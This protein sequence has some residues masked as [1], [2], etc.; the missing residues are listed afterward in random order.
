V[1]AQLNRGRQHLGMPSP[2]PVLGDSLPLPVCNGT[3]RGQTLRRTL[4]A[5]L[6]MIQQMKVDA[7]GPLTAQQASQLQEIEMDA[8][9]LACQLNDLQLAMASDTELVC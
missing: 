9:E 4:N 6:E 1:K 5:M 3:E 2:T 8:L 7:Q